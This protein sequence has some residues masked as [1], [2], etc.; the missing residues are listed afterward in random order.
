M[1]KNRSFCL[2]TAFL[3]CLAAAA[4]S[5]DSTGNNGS[6]GIA[7][8]PGTGTL[9]LSLT[10][11]PTD[12]YRAVYVKID[13]IQVHTGGDETVDGNWKTVA[14]PMKIYNLLEFVNGALEE[15]GTAILD[16]GAYQQLRLIIGT[17]PTDDANILGVGHPYANYAIGPDNGTHALRIPSAI[18][19]GIKLV[20]GFVVSK[21][22]TTRLILDFDASA[23]VV[24]AGNSG[25]WQLK[26]SIKVLDA[27]EHAMV[28]GIV[29]ESV[30]SKTGIAGA[31]ISLQYTPP[32]TDDPK[33]AVAVRTA[34]ASVEGDEGGNI[35]TGEY[36][37]SSDPGSYRLVSYKDGYSVDC[38]VVDAVSG[39]TT[40]RDVE[41]TP[42]A[43]GTVEGNVLVNGGSSDQYVTLS[44]RQSA[45]CGGTGAESVIEVRS[46]SIAAGYWYQINLPAGAYSLA[47]FST[48]METVEY[49]GIEVTDGG[50]FYQNVS[51]AP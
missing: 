14:A 30:D 47:A 3:C 31:L 9:S 27:Q 44:F 29:S 11:A 2:I 42:S 12:L 10:D 51:L 37:L 43:M 32:E 20:H 13:E 40:I 16:T 8:D 21:N 26:P 17:A 4:C 23:S 46:V 5:S 48:G 15:L 34:T 49:T 25:D 35:E 22:A 36:L 33:D 7:G 41:L 38:A 6:G 24:Q 50:V 18:N 39:Q 19:T 28:G 45:R 1:R